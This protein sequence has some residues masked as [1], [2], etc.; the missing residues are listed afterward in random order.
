MH[1]PLL[2]GG[3]LGTVEGQAVNN[4]AT[5]NLNCPVGYASAKVLDTSGQDLAFSYCFAN[6]VTSADNKAGHLVGGETLA[7]GQSLASLNGE[8]YASTTTDGKFCVFHESDGSTV[9]CSAPTAAEGEGSY[10]T[11]VQ[12]DGNLCTYRDIGATAVWCSSSARSGN[13]CMLAEYTSDQSLIIWCS[14]KYASPRAHNP[15]LVYGSTYHIQNNYNAW[16]GG[17]LDVRASGCD[18]NKLCVSTSMQP[19]SGL[20]T[21]KWTVVAPRHFVYTDQ[22]L[23]LRNLYTDALTGRTYLDTREGTCEGNPRC[24]S[25]SDTPQRDGGTGT[26]RFQ[27]AVNY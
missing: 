14:F 17:F 26:W 23:N 27:P 3:V 1:Q 9:W 10:F 25:T 15:R 12:A 20:N 21:S 2:F 6:T 18:N 8:F 24:V 4:P 5:G 22:E 19:N 11:A 13:V 16:S 7:A